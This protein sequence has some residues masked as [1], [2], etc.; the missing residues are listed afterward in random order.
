MNQCVIYSEL[1]GCRYTYYIIIWFLII[2]HIHISTIIIAIYFCCYNTLIKS[3]Y[4]ITWYEIF[5]QIFKTSIV[6]NYWFL[7]SRRNIIFKRLPLKKP[8]VIFCWFHLIQYDK[9][10]IFVAKYLKP[11][12]YF[13]WTSLWYF[14]S[15]SCNIKM[16]LMLY[17]WK[18]L[19][20]RSVRSLSS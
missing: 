16:I 5:L 20:K 8:K 14:Q 2:R 19:K 7:V 10:D 13:Y 4:L 6:W 18:S 1:F 3:F 12:C 15:T 9:N 17:M 11:F